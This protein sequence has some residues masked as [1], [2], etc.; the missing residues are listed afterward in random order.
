MTGTFLCVIGVFI[1][2]IFLGRK[3]EKDM[4]RQLLAKKEKEAEDKKEKQ[5]LKNVTVMARKHRDLVNK[6]R[7]IYAKQVAESVEKHFLQLKA[8]EKQLVY[9]NDYGQ[10]IFDD[11][12][13][14]LFLFSK[15][16]VGSEITFKFEQIEP[17]KKSYAY[18]KKYFR[19]FRGLGLDFANRYLIWPNSFFAFDI[20]R[21]FNKMP[22][23]ISIEDT[24]A[25]IKLYFKIKNLDIYYEK[26]YA[27]DDAEYDDYEQHEADVYL[28]ELKV[29]SY[30][31]GEY[32][33]AKKSLV[34]NSN[35]RHDEEPMMEK[36]T[37]L[38]YEKAIAATLKEMGFDA[39]TTK[40]SGDQGADVLA[41]KNG[42]S[43]AIQCKMYSKP[44]GNKA[45]Q[46]ANAGRDFYSCDYGVVVSNA[47]FTKAARQAA[48]AC[49]VI[50]LDDNQLYKLL[51]YTQKKS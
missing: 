45:V 26:I 44:V 51:S 38:D 46:E 23:L 33:V 18:F 2:F 22:S 32:Y 21:N 14:E 29:R 27:D 4:E 31:V 35:D 24:T 6:Y 19:Y 36:I 50:L 8:K 47:G 11:F 5:R 3:H 39:R 12:Y 28:N 30:I 48:H 42:I 43:F 40:A 34:S 16:V 10:V 37:P 13:K 7:G 49:N 41:Q 20:E 9:T 15:N 17:L 1:F 25:R